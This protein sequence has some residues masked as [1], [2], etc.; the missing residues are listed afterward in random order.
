MSAVVISGVTGLL[1]GLVLHWAGFSRPGTL[2]DAIALR[3]SYGLRSGLYAIG[4]SMALTALLCWLAVIDVDGIVVL[5]LSAG[6][7]AGGVIFGAAAG[8]GGFT[9][10]TAAAGVGG[11]P[12]AEALCTLAGCG[13]MTLALP[14]LSEPL[15]MLRTLPPGSSE[16]LFRVTLDEPYVL[17]GGFLGQGCAGLLLAAVAVCVPSPRLR[18]EVHAD[19]PEVQ[20]APDGNL[21]PAGEA[22]LLL[23]AA[24]PEETFVALLPGEEPLVVDTA[25]D[26]PE[27]GEP[28]QQKP[29][30]TLRG[31]RRTGGRRFARRK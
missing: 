16:T 31:W 27:S 11:G 1:L 19:T 10:E 9:P 13:A 30:R 22:L 5:P 29:L 21:P 17:G 23:P 18:P 4:M 28:P 20:S 12:A 26:E 2:R 25:L 3:R 8:L 6:T 24:V 7:L 14:L 15:D